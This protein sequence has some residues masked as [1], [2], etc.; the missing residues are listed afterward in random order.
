MASGVSITMTREDRRRR[1]RLLL[2]AA[3][4]AVAV[5]VSVG[6]SLLFAQ[7]GSD[8]AVGRIDTGVAGTRVPAFA[9]PNL[10]GGTIRLDD[11]RGSVVV[12]NFWASWC[13]PCREEVG[14]LRELDRRWRSRGVRVIGVVENDT[15]AEAQLFRWRHDVAWGSGVDS[16]RTV[17]INFGVRGV[18]ET[19]VVDRSGRLAGKVL[20]RLR[21]G[22]LDAML[23]SQLAKGVRPAPVNRG[24]SP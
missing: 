24:S 22:E 19:Y 16:G 5:V 7:A 23:A 4:A 1:R 21:V 11:L 8:S 3:L 15:P 17:G 13:V 18:P 10:D 6:A 2:V 9:I 14:A 20:G 12:V